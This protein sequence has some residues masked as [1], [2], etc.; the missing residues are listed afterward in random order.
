M[1]G[2]NNEIRIIQR[3]AYGIKNQEYL[4]L[5]VL[6]SFIKEPEEKSFFFT[7]KP[8]DPSFF[9]YFD[10]TINSVVEY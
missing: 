10:K 3:R 6:T 1:E 7:I 2:L 8:E 5:K 9:Y 4:R